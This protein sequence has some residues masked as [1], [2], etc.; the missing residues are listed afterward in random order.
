[1]FPQGPGFYQKIHIGNSKV[2]RGE[3]KGK[4]IE[5]TWVDFKRKYQNLKK[6]NLSKIINKIKKRSLQW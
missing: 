6:P 3:A 1:M 5:I 4:E 2:S